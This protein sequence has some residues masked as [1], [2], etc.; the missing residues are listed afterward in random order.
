MKKDE[1][2]SKRRSRREELQGEMDAF[3]DKERARQDNAA[4]E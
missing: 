4:T 1:Q 3:L 2:K